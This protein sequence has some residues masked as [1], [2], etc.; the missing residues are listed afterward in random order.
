MNFNRVRVQALRVRVR[1]QRYRYFSIDTTHTDENIGN[2]ILS[3]HKLFKGR[4]WSKIMF[5]VW[6]AFAVKIVA[7]MT[8]ELNLAW[9]TR[10]EPRKPHSDDVTAFSII[11]QRA[12]Q[13]PYN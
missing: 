2:F 10:H 12:M 8:A 3:M 6:L 13:R 1:V 9:F 11:R 7:A 4:V 5:C